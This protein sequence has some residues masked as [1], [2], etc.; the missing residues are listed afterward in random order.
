MVVFEYLLDMGN[1]SEWYQDNPLKF[2]LARSVKQSKGGRL[3]GRVGEQP[4]APLGSLV[5]LRSQSPVVL[6]A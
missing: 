1:P 2:S 6:H 4:R 3:L 5:P